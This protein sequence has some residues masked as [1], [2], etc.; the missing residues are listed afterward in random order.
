MAR[1][2]YPRRARV[3]GTLMLLVALGAAGCT[4]DPAAED[5]PDAK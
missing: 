4:G 5:S 2:A 3:T 1:K